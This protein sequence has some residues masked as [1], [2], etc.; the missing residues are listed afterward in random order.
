MKNFII[1]GLML[2]SFNVF[3][4]S[5]LVLNNGITLT[6]DSAGFVYDFG[7]FHMPYKVTVNG[8]QFLVANN[9]LSTIDSSG[10]LY[11]KDLRIDTVKITGVNYFIRND[12]MLVTIDSNGM[13]YVYDE[14]IFKSIVGYGG[15]FFIVKAD[16]RK[17]IV[18]L[19]TIS[20]SG[21]Y[22]KIDVVGLNPD[23]IS[24]FGGN[25]FQTPSGVVYTISKEGFV[26]PKPTIAVGEIKKIGGN[27]LI[28]SKNI[29]F[30]IAEDGMLS[31]PVVPVNFN[32]VN[33]EMLGS[34][35][36]IDSDGKIF[37]VDKFGNLNE[38]TIDHDI[39]N[40][41]ILSL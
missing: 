14:K 27:F 15:S 40:T 5:Y 11:K 12:N 19:Y 3:S 26:Y 1:A 41:K 2:A 7:H 21:N 32:I 33:I 37:V 30:T 6:T 18:D 9:V 38:R 4:Q 13:Y 17:S 36:L 23:D 34:N 22:F 31:I 39:R 20:S 28:N 29:I 35:Y 16:S 24:T 25:F 8:G 10:F